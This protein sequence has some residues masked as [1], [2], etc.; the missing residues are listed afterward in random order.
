MVIGIIGVILTGIILRNDT[1][2]R[3]VEHQSEIFPVDVFFKNLCKFTFLDNLTDDHPGT[4]PET[5]ASFC[6]FID[7]RNVFI[8]EIFQIVFVRDHHCRILRITLAYRNSFGICDIR[9][10]FVKSRVFVVNIVCFAFF[11]ISDFS[12]LYRN[13]YQKIEIHIRLRSRCNYA[14][15]IV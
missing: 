2:C 3:K 13:V 14:L 11:P 8:R 4:Y 10:F 5:A 6:T 12:G 15:I 9:S 7:F 1:V